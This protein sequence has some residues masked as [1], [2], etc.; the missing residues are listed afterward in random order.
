MLSLQRLLLSNNDKFFDLLESSASEASLC[1]AELA[2]LLSAPPEQR[3]L[4]GLIAIRR[5]NKVVHEEIVAL[6]CSSFVTP[7][8]RE[9]IEAVSRR[10][11]R[12]PKMIEKFSERLL[13]SQS[14]IG[15]ESFERQ[16]GL[17]IQATETVQRMVAH[18][19]HRIDLEQVG[20]ENS[21]LQQ[22]E[23]TADQLMLELLGELY[24]DGNTP[25]HMIVTRDLFELLERAIDRCRDVGNVIIQIALKNQ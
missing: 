4:Q 1:A 11:Y 17:L 7:L 5:R 13:L 3:S 19:R 24:H 16:V 14:L 12:I 15:D 9:D 23:R 10:L 20:A 22:Y 25:L 6:L 8:E 18:L 21:Q 2:E